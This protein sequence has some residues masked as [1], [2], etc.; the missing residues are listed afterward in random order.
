MIGDNLLIDADKVKKDLNEK[1]WAKLINFFDSKYIHYGNEKINELFD[2]YE[3]IQKDKG[4][5]KLTKNTLHH[6]PI[7][8]PGF[9]EVTFND[10]LYDLLESI[11][12]GKII[13]NCFGVSRINPNEITY[14]QKI[15]R[16]ARDIYSSQDMLNLIILFTDSSSEN[17]G[18]WILEGS[19]KNPSHIKPSLDDFNKKAK[20]ITGSAGDLIVF[21]PFMW[22]C[23]GENK[24]NATRVV[25][26]PIVTRPFIKPGLD[27]VRGL[28]SDYFLTCSEKMKQ[29]FGYYSRVPSN[30]NEFYAKDDDRFYKRDQ[31]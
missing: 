16:D 15:H 20:I 9:A 11:F 13:I 29:L 27:Y 17:G 21:N 10:V 2:V 12:N 28:G 30:L 22:H 4:V 8:C 31:K 7:L 23:S 24:S 1:G 6:I 26:T 18:T 14:T 25:L 5:E 3:K 19:H